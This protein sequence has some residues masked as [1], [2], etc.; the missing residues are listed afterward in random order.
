MSSRCRPWATT[1]CSSACRPPAICGS[2]VH[3]FYDGFARED[4]LGRPGY[5]GHEGVGEVVESRSEL[6]RPGAKVLTVPPGLVW[7]VVSLS[8]NP[9]QARYSLPLPAGGDLQRLLMAQQLG[10]TIFALRKFWSGP[11][12]EVA[13]VIGAGSAGLFFL[14]QLKQVGF[15]KI[16]ICD[17]E[18]GRLKVAARPLVRRPR[19]SDR[20]NQSSTRPSPRAMGRV[21]ILLSKPQGTTRRVR[22]R[23][24]ASGNGVVASA[25][26][27][28]PERYGPA[29]FPFERAYRK[30]VTIEF[31]VDTS[32]EPGLRSYIEAIDAVHGRTIDVGY[33][34]N[35]HFPLTRIAE[36]LE[37][38]LHAR[39]HGSIKMR[40][41]L[42]ASGTSGNLAPAQ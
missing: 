27:A 36:A 8:S 42:E 1:T 25:S 37:L 30:A 23:S 32:L 4:A 29:A 9:V 16:V 21:P 41:D 11:G 33:S 17:L 20:A 26:L 40:A 39:G 18:P 19:C 31:I 35:E 15:K 22:S 14:Q 24:S 28:Y 5:P 34:L 3:V 2:D 10:T 6:F 38:R 7:G 13:T 12:G